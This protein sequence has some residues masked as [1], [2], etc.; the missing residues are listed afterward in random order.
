MPRFLIELG[1]LIFF[2]ILIFILIFLSCP[3]CSPTCQILIFGL[4]V[5]PLSL[6]ALSERV[7]LWRRT[8]TIIR[9]RISSFPLIVPP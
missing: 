3:G 6:P 2:I 5:M 8:I 9:P 7:C 4:V 1:L